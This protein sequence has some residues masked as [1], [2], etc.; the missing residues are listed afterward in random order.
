MK[1]ILILLLTISAFNLTAQTNHPNIANT[2]TN[3][4]AFIPKGWKMIY[5]AHGDLNKDN[6]VDE[7][8]IIENTNPKN[9]IKND[10][11][12]GD[13]LNVNPRIL[14]ILLKQKSGYQLIA[15]NQKFIPTENDT[16][17]TCLTDPLQETKAVDILRGALVL[18]YQYWLSCGSYEVSSVD[19]TFRYQ[20]NKFQLIG[21]DQSGYSRSSG[22]KSATSINFST[23]KISS[24]YGGNMFDEKADK[25]KTTWKKLNWKKLLTLDEMNEDWAT[26]LADL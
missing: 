10:G 24:T 21:F 12:G 6:L 9:I 4:N 13:K 8:L 3:T 22:E 26:K 11:M 25:P 14:L 2:G 1:N 20:N 17:T 16:V 7:A 5:Q 19:Y 15:Q 18:S 23:Q